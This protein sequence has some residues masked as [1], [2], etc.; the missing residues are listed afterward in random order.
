MLREWGNI[1][2]PRHHRRCL[3][4]AFASDEMAIAIGTI[5]R[6][7]QLRMPRRER[8]RNSPRTAPR[9]IAVVPRRDVEVVVAAKQ[10]YAG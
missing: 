1:G 5:M 7:V 2:G 9:G 8:R 10:A 4:A 6:T 3:G